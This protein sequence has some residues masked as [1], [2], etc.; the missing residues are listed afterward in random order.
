MLLIGDPLYIEEQR[1]LKYKRYKKQYHRNTEQKKA[2]ILTPIS[3][4]VDFKDGNIKRDKWTQKY[5]NYKFF[6]NSIT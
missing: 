4:K 6:M 2:G 5:N 1:E 3:G